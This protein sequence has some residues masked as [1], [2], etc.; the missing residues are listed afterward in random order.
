MEPPLGRRLYLGHRAV[1]DALDAKMREHG[2]SIWSWIL[3]KTAAEQL[4]SAGADVR[5]VVCNQGDPAAVIELFAQLDREGLVADGVVINAATNPVYG[6]LLD[7]DLGAWQKI[8]D[9]N[10]TGALLTA[11]QACRRLVPRRRGALLF[12]A[13]VAGLD[14]DADD[15]SSKIADAID[16][17]VEKNER[18]RKAKPRAAER[19]GGEMNTGNKP[20]RKRPASLNEAVKKHYDQAR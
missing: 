9:V 3:L 7:L 19:S 15:F 1:H 17:A 18:L 16:T 12:L 10:L 6:P 2:A 11:Q 5:T 14:P 20:Q 13:S 8:L 4:R